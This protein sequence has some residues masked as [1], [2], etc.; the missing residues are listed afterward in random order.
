[1]RQG[2]LTIAAL[3]RSLSPVRTAT[4]RWQRVRTCAPD[5][6]K[7]KQKSVTRWRLNCFPSL[8]LLKSASAASVVTLASIIT[9]DV[10][11]LLIRTDGQER[12]SMKAISN[13]KEFICNAIIPAAERCASARPAERKPTAFREA[14]IGAAVGNRRH[15]MRM[16]TWFLS[17]FVR[18]V[19]S[20]D[21]SIGGRGH[22]LVG[23][24]GTYHLPA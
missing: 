13:Q 8:T 10:R 11:S 1:M 22:E 18:F 24:F 9:H 14:H 20:S 21:V 19:T 23:T 5:V 16:G 6:R 15:R 17:P 4:E 12:D 3:V 2:S 7:K